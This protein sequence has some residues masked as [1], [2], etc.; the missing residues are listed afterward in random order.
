M[1][2][3]LLF[4]PTSGTFFDPKT[5]GKLAKLGSEGRSTSTT[6]TAF[7]VLKPAT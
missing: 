6:I 7:A 5:R 1:R 2:A 3:P 4:D